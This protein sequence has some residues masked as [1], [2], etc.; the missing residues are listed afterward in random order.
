MLQ[1]K[2]STHRL[3]APGNNVALVLYKILPFHEHTELE[4]G[5]SHCSYI[6]DHNY[7][8]EVFNQ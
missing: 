1:H 6:S 2:L 8:H 7:I 3:S 5:F 4:T